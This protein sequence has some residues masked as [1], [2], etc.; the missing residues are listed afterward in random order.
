MVNYKI[1]L[2][3]TAILLLFITTV[4]SNSPKTPESKDW[5]FIVYMAA[6]NNL[7]SFSV[8]NLQQMIH[9]GST[10]SLNILLQLDGYKQKEVTRYF[11]EKNNPV[12][13][14]EF[15]HTNAS[16]SGTTES[17][18]DFTKWAIETYPAKHQ[19][20]VLWNHGCGIKDP[21]IWGKK[22][23]AH[24]DELF[25]FNYSNGL[26]ELNRNILDDEYDQRGIAFN[27]TFETYITNQELQKTL[28]RI[29][30]ELLG[31]KKIDILAMDAC[32]MAMIEI[33]SQIKDSTHY[34]VASE[35]IEPGSGYNYI[36]T[37]DPFIKESLTPA[38]FAAH[39]VTSYEKEYSNFNADF[40]LSA[41]NL[42][43][44][45]LL[46]ENMK[47]IT[48]ALVGLLSSEHTKY[49]GYILK[50]IRMS[51]RFTTEFCD[52]DYIDLT[53][54]YKSLLYKIETCKE[55]EIP[56][57]ACQKITAFT[58]LVT[59]GLALLEKHIIK[60]A[61]GINLDYA[62]GLSV[63]F[64]RRSVASSYYKTVFEEV[65]DW[66]DFLHAYRKAARQE[67]PSIRPIFNPLRWTS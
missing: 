51:R 16:I 35:E 31:G 24:R 41:I 22:I 55:M 25:D 10:N 54:F 2:N 39:I 60:N 33:G 46:E 12:I 48:H 34:M 38:E 20:I 14:E 53:H 4:F 26:L 67:K 15:Q 6:N 64:P 5:N 59:E 13:I 45:D 49:I 63:Y 9:V 11:I 42:E 3:N 19:C 30:T 66:A 18:Y 40:T 29:S 57:D 32:H 23:M 44:F 43:G 56:L 47:Q 7:Y 21:N 27:D 37:L 65:T 58:G 52:P 62:H 28:C 36:Y 50:S 61:A 8:R 17:L 1:L